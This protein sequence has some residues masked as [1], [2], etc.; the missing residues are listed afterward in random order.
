LSKS[1]SDEEVNKVTEVSDEKNF[2]VRKYT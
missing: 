1:S 2:K